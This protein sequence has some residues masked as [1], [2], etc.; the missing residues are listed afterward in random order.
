MNIRLDG[1]VALVTGASSGIGKGVAIALA[2]S[3]ADVVVNY[4]SDSGREAA[5]ATG[6]AIE[7][8]GRRA[9]LIKADMSDPEQIAA[10][11]DQADAAFGRLDILVN[12]AGIGGEGTGIDQT[13][14]DWQR[15]IAVNLTAPYICTQHAVRLMR[16][17]GAG[18]RILNI[19]SVHEEAPGGGA[20]AYTASKAGLRNLT[21]ASALQLAP[22]G[23]YVVS[24]A[25]GMILT[26]MNAEASE[27]EETL[28]AAEAQI[29][30]RRAGQPA[31]IGNVVTF[32]ASD[33]ASYITGSTIFVDGGWMLEWPPV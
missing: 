25:P 21:R 23:I 9:V 18:G 11:F 28:R 32:L 24:V 3:G 6:K 4:R 33:E 19:T 26:N 13:L 30:A 12:N 17:G 2:Q 16:R 8:A 29:P 10:L 20:I 22:E 5:E 7:E 27:D 31:D 15:V 1:K 14:D